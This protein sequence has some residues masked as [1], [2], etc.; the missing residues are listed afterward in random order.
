[1][2]KL[3]L[4]TLSAFVFLSCDGLLLGSEGHTDVADYLKPPPD[5]GDGIH[6]SSM[7]DEQIDAARM[8]SLVETLSEDK[9]NEIRS[10]LV[11]RN[12]KLVLEAYFNGWSRDRKQDLRSATKSFTSAIVGIAIDKGIIKGTEE[13]V[14]GF[15]PEYQSFA[16][17]DERKAQMTIRDFL[18]MR[19]GLT[20]NDWNPQSAGHEEKMYDAHDWVKFVLDLPATGT[21]GTE[22]SYCTGAPVTLGAIVSN[23]SGKSIPEFASENLFQPL[24][25]NDYA[26]EFMP[27][28][29]ADTGGHLHMRPRDMMKFG[30]LFLNHGQWN[31]TQIIS[32]DWVEESTRPDG[33]V[34]GRN[35]QYGYLWWYTTGSVNGNTLNGYFANGNGGQLIFIF[36]E[37]DMVIVFTGGTYNRDSRAF[38]ILGSILGSV[39]M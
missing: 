7:T 24:G 2:N 9:N 18:R 29:R 32:S 1:M 14:I 36:E 21:A 11:A 33:D 10:I 15:F 13:K 27:N 39:Q 38:S 28:G 5:M 3:S 26:W 25:I 22:Y 6:V 23:A 20:C 8:Y 31:G 16:N 34:P 17:W 19:T 4:I 12:N 30:L 35:T 37:I